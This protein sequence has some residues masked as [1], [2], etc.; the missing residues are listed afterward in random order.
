M[1][2]KLHPFKRFGEVEFAFKSLTLLTGL[3]SGGKTSV[4]QALLLGRLLDTERDRKTIPEMLE[5]G[6]RSGLPLGDAPDYFPYESNLASVTFSDES[7]SLTFTIQRGETDILLART[8]DPEMLLQ[9]KWRV[10]SPGSVPISREQFVENR[11]LDDSIL[12]GSHAL[13]ELVDRELSPAID[14]TTLARSPLRNAVENNLSLV[15]S[16]TQIKVGRIAP[17]QDRISLEFRANTVESDW[18]SPV[19]H[20]AGVTAALPILTHM[21]AAQEG[22]TLILQD[23]EIHLHPSGQSLLGRLLVR[24]A[25]RGVRVI[26]ESHSE[27]I[28][29]GI[30][31]GVLSSRLSFD[32]FFSCYYLG[33]SNGGIPE[34]DL[35]MIDSKGR[36]GN[37]PAGFFDQAEADLGAI[38]RG[39]FD[40]RNGA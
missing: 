19:H 7:T 32:D 26:V 25:N 8:N 6:S 17:L 10:V 14:P 4:L 21:C 27:H 35:I 30:R 31:L 33:S 5:F 2:A 38:L 9:G 16:P 39:N 28:L 20:G 13:I 11:S 40:G 29:N 36:I 18:L 24:V 37:W 12:D 15:C 3:N 23:P 1:R 34:L 22:D